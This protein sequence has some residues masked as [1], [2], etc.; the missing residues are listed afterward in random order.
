MAETDQ[1]RTEAPTARRR[2]EAR[3]SGQVAKSMD[4]TAAAALL[5]AVLLLYAMGL[6]MLGEFR[7]SMQILLPGS[8]A[9]NTARAGDM[10]ESMMLAV[11][12]MALAG[13]PLM[14]SLMAVS[15]VVNLLQVGPLLTPKPLEPKW[16]K[17][18]PLR[19]LKSLFDARSAVRLTMSLA[20]VG[21]LGATAAWIIY[22]DLPQ[23]LYLPT[24]EP[25]ALFGSAA[26]MVYMLALKL[27]LLLL[28]LGVA[29]Y[30]FQRWQLERDLR[31]TKQEI[32]EEFKRM[33]GDPLIKQRR[34]RVAR[35]LALQRVNQAVPRADVIVTNPT[36]F[37][38]ALQYDGDTMHAPKVVAKGAD[39]LAAR[40]RQLAMI[41][42]VPIVERKELA[43]ALYREVEVGQFIPPEFFAAVA[44]ILAYV[45]RL[46]G[47]RSA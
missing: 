35:Q 19:G 32:I 22:Q 40:I 24:L 45:Y 12:K 34:T 33:E 36:H 25:M 2:Q 3:E 8:L 41:H 42:G 38:V 20:K 21:L 5:A 27:A 10:W 14:L 29:D 9:D 1:E 6:R 30:A 44:E 31:M 39:Y 18:S 47:R 15:L 7:S 4:L 13:G 17:L 23:I 11:R 46:S 26:W 28:V 43:R 37:A 16:S